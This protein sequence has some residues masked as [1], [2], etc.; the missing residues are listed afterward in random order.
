[1]I[2]EGAWAAADWSTAFG[3]GL[4]VFVLR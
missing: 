1:M 2:E 3:T 4:L